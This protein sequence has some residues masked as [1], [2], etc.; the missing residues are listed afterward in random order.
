MPALIGARLAGDG[1]RSFGK[2]RRG[3]EK[4]AVV[5]AAIKAMAIT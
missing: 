1:H 5:L 4:R 2:D 3:V